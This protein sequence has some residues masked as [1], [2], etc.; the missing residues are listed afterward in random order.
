MKEL[1]IVANKYNTDKGTA[2]TGNSD[3]MTNMGGAVHHG[4]TEFYDYYFSKYKENCPTILEIGVEMGGSIRML[5]DYFHGNCEIWCIDINAYCKD[6]AES[7]GS[8][9]H[10]VQLDQSDGNALRNFTESLFTTRFDIIIDDGSHVCTHQMHTL[11]YLYKYLNNDGIYII[12]D[13]HTTFSPMYNENVNDKF[14]SPIAFF[15]E[16]FDYA[17]YTREENDKIHNA[18]KSATLFVTKNSEG[19]KI[20]QADTGVICSTLL[21]KFNKIQ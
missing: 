8:N 9:I 1:T 17:Y 10:F 3:E 21:L 18:V 15:T 20:K 4:Y 12:E 6:I 14:Y 19:I 11:K 5:N 16:G 2:Y 7:V 13:T